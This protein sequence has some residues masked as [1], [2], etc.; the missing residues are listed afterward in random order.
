MCWSQRNYRRKYELQTKRKTEA[1]SEKATDKA[2]A[3]IDPS[4]KVFTMDLQSVLLC[5]KLNAS[6]LYNRT[7]ICCYNFT[8][9]DAIFKNVMCY[10][11][12][13]TGAEY[14]HVLSCLFTVFKCCGGCGF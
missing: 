4:I 3:Q 2:N 9:F 7:K 13:E 14:A 1:A 8:L 5:P 12:N 10:F 6:A 11:F